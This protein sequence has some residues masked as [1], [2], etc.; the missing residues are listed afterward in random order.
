MTA[1]EKE[2]IITLSKA[3]KG[4]N[5]VKINYDGENRIVEPYLIGELYDKF[6][7]DMKEGVYAL[8]AWLV[9]GYSSQNLDIKAGDRWRIYHI[10]K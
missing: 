7:S 6:S 3:I 2:I 8:R 4:R 1:E 9:S 10:E 5:L